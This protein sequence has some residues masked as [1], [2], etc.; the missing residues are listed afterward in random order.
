ME[1][2]KDGATRQA[3]GREEGGATEEHD[4]AVLRA[5]T[6]NGTHAAAATSDPSQESGCEA[7]DEAA[8]MSALEDLLNLHVNTLDLYRQFAE[9][10]THFSS[11]L[12]MITGYRILRQDPVECLFQFICSSNNHISRISSMVEVLSQQGPLVATINGRPFHA[13]PSLHRLSSLSEP[14]LRERGFGY[15]AAFIVQT[16]CQLHQMQATSG[17]SGSEWLQAMRQQAW[18]E[19][20]RELCVLPGVGPKVAACVALL[21]LDQHAA[22]PVDTHVWQVRWSVV[23]WLHAVLGTSAVLCG[24]VRV[25]VISCLK[26]GSRQQVWQE[27]GRQLCML[28]GVGPQGGAC[29]A[30]LSLDQHAARRG[31]PRWR[32][33]GTAVVGPACCQA[34]APKV[35]RVWHCCRWT[36]ML[37]GVGPQGGACVALLS[38]DQH[39]A[40]RGPPRWR[41][42]GTA[43][44]GPAC[45]QAWAPKVARVWH[46]CRWTSM[47]PGVGPQG[48]ACV[49]LLSLDQHAARRGPPRWRVCGT[50]VVGPACCQA[51]APK[52]ARVWHCCRWTSM[53]PGV[54]P[55]GGACVALL[56]LD[57]HAARR[58]PPRWRV[59]GTA[60]V[61]PACCQAWAPKVARVWHCC[62][63]TSML[64]GVGPQG[65]ACV[66]LLSLDQHAARRGPPRWR[67]CGTAVVG[68]ACCQ[69]W[70]PKVARV[71]HCCRWTSMLPGV[72]PQG[73]A[74]VALLSLD[75]HAARRGP[76]RWRV[77]GTAVVGPACCQAWA[78][79][80]ARVWHCCRWTSMLPGVG[81]QGGACVA[82]LSLDQHAA[83]RGPPRWR[84]CGTA[85]V[86]PACCQAW[87]PK[88]ARVWHCCRWTSMLPGVGPQGGAC[89]ALLSLDQHAARRGPPRWRVCGTAVVG[90]ACCQA[91]APKVARV[92]HCCRWT[93]MLPG[94]GPQGGACVALLSLDQHAARRGPPRWRVC[95]TAVVGP[96]CCQAWAPKVARVWHCCRWTSMLPGVGPQ[97]GAC[98]A[99]LSLDQHAARR[100]PPRWRVCGTAVVGP[101]C[102][103]AWAPKVARV[104]H[105]CRW[106]SMLPGVGPQGGACVALLSLD[107]HAARRGPPRWRVCGTAVVGPA[108][109][110]AWAP[111]V[112][113]VWHC[114]RWTSMLPGVGPQGGACVALLSLDQHAARRG[115]PRWRVCGTAVVG[116]ACCQAWAPKVARV[117]H[118]CRWTSMLPGVGPQ[119]GACVAL[120]S[121][122]QH[123]AR[124]GPPRWRVCGTAVVGPA[125]CQA[126]APKVAR[127]WHC[128]RWTS[129]LPGVGPQGGACVALL[130]LDQHAAR[131]GPPRW[132]VCGTAVVGPA[133]C[134]AWAPK[135]ARVWHCCRWTSMLPGVG[136]QGGACVALLSLDQH[137]ARR[138][139]PRWRV[140]GTA[141]VGPACCQAWAPKVA[142]V[143]H[144][145]RWT[146]ML[147]GVGPQGG[148]CVA[149]L[150][151]DQHAAR[152]GPPR[153]RVCGTAV[154][155]PACCQAW[156]PKV[157]RVWHCC[158]WTSMLPGVGPQGGACVALLSLDQHAARRGPPRWRVCG[159]AVV[160]PACCQAW[161][162]KVARVWHCCRWT[163]MLPGVGP[164]GGACVA[165]LSL[166]QHAARRGHPRLAGAAVLYV[167]RCGAGWYELAQ[168]HYASSIKGKT[169]T[170]R[171]RVQLTQALEQVFGP[172]CGWAVNAMFASELPAVK[173]RFAAAG[174]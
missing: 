51:W 43:V 98:V 37:P 119:G 85:V 144:C 69:A 115:P 88:V 62:R 40:R 133:C 160:G 151:L 102:C 23:S 16:A 78:P 86:G 159:T 103:Q 161:A 52:V 91:W 139:P 120:L 135:V 48:G 164:Q 145:C 112:A 34:W 67:V 75:Q 100:G 111:K 9:C 172:M 44:V 80:V 17:T 31:P 140:C 138:G 109:C 147:P 93:S 110:Q 6:A 49:A 157:A 114:C 101:A 113:R 56:S 171:V 173:A 53:L 141:V 108:C 57:Q 94:V 68:P 149:L 77:C 162:P 60:V 58:G 21:S 106:T 121:L 66:A 63:W 19:V 129:M 32:V 137:A 7:A 41:V 158:R 131:R 14:Y 122:D 54:G 73:G 87:A 150:S 46:C 59:C 99:L 168:R 33:C 28:P 126:W 74:C 155:G 27:V 82:L 12:P 125:C 154:V 50:A 105:C 167:V 97:G 15:R 143:W 22:V 8:V 134:Q 18:Q 11:L 165:L 116:P 153:W 148:A 35:A 47:L 132:R 2:G 104:W 83:R 95:G 123:A 71:W 81:P 72:G 26:A 130:S 36:S 45:C 42:C 128:C 169:L 10:D 124:R 174:G 118:C 127:V 152:R 166:D 3:E 29:V 107:Q 70:A 25:W 92:W 146:S 5:M 79:K 84:V 64:P 96:A 163:S 13:F 24:E 156:A 39:A 1:Q 89:V 76:P 61:G 117:W 65:G 55:Q 170:A 4:S 20:E 142:R 90:P 38:L 136:P 30:L